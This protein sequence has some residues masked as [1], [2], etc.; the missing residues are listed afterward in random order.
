MIGV[1]FYV[2]IS[3]VAFFALGKAH[4]TGWVY[5]YEGIFF[6]WPSNYIGSLQW[7]VT[8]L[9]GTAEVM[10]G[11]LP[12]R[13]FSA[14]HCL[15]SVIVLGLFV[16]GLTMVM[17]AMQ[18]VGAEKRKLVFSLST[19]MKAHNIRSDLCIQVMRYLKH[20][21]KWE[22]KSRYD[23]EE[24][25][26]LSCLPQALRRDL[27]R[28]VRWPVIGERLLMKSFQRACKTFTEQVFCGLLQSRQYSAGD[29]VYQQGLVCSM[30]YFVVSGTASYLHWGR[31]FALTTSLLREQMPE[32]E[33]QCYEVHRR[34]H[35]RRVKEV[36]TAF[37]EFALFVDWVTLGDLEVDG[38]LPLSLFV[39]DSVA[40]EQAVSTF[41]QIQSAVADHAKY[42]LATLSRPKVITDLIC[43]EDIF[44]ATGHS[45]A[46]VE[47]DLSPRRSRRTAKLW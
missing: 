28:E 40:F 33:A 39:L 12:E 37:C 6:S 45:P 26:I 3:G 5:R 10:P 11:N 8:E 29:R 13:Q 41:V 42:V 7:A 4:A 32:R 21:D 14:A 24:A 15:M 23:S 43:S 44:V 25:N 18:E 17:Q 2:H 22:G 9:Q 47:E 19:Y 35:V 16:S 27:L 30:V 46:A 36:G 20:K 31:M 34:D 38:L 1:I